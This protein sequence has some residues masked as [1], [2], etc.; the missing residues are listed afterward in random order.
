MAHR[1]NHPH[2]DTEGMTA[3]RPSEHVVRLL[4]PFFLK[5]AALDDAVGALT[6]ARYVETRE[7]QGAE[8][9]IWWLWEQASPAE[10][11]RKEVLDHVE[12]FLF[13]QDPAACRLQALHR[14]EP[15]EEAGDGIGIGIDDSVELVLRHGRVLGDRSGFRRGSAPAR[16][17]GMSRKAVGI[18]R[19]LR[20][21]RRT[22]WR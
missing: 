13:G 15:A 16:I 7:R 4:R 12:A 21:G 17:G 1:R 2:V 14:A 3:L 19:Q 10:R 20:E 8:R 6:R 5:R 11:Y 18:R 22:A 9:R